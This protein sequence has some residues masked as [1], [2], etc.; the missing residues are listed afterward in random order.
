[1]EYI[2]DEDIRTILL[3]RGLSTEGTRDEMISRISG[4]VHSLTGPTGPTG[5][6]GP[7]GS[8]GFTSSA[9]VNAKPKSDRLRFIGL[10]ECIIL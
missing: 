5:P 10:G 8:T 4:N 9:D 1:M 7:T 6:I 3:S 2:T